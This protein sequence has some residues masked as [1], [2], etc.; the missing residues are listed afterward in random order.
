MDLV[1]LIR[2]LLVAIVGV[3][4]ILKVTETLFNIQVP[5]V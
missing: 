4:A 1:D 2:N 3:Y 5:V